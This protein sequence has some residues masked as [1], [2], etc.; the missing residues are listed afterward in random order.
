MLI[1]K[2]LKSSPATKVIVAVSIIAIVAF[3]TYNWVVSPQITYLQAAKKYKM[4][5]GSAGEKTTVINNNI[6]EKQKELDTL[7]QDVAKLQNS[8]FSAEKARE[9]FSDL[10]PI[11]VQHKCNVES[12]T[13]LPP[14]S[15]ETEDTVNVTLNHANIVLTGQYKD[16]ME[17]IVKIRDYPQ[18][19]VIGNLLI[20]SSRFATGELNCQINITIYTIEDK[21]SITHEQE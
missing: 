14:E 12:L 2:T 13:F 11:A 21:E 1:E 4:I 6:M 7:R 19:I 18:R 8:F 20:E 15:K 5:V 17:F 9:F 16:I 3:V 10:E